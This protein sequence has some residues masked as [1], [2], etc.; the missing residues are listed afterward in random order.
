MIP[1]K[2]FSFFFSE[3]LITSINKRAFRTL[4]EANRHLSKSFET[5][6]TVNT[7]QSSLK[8]TML[9]SLTMSSC[10]NFAIEAPAAN[11]ITMSFVLII[12]FIVKIIF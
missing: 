2:S 12:T 1:F 8:F 3:L 11:P 4:T 6:L 10:F 7:R 5:I 9:K